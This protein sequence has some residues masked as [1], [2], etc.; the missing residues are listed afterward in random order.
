MEKLYEIRD[1]LCEELEKTAKNGELSTGELDIVHKI[2][3]TIKN[4]DKIC[5]MEE[6]GGYS[7]ESSY[8][9][10]MNGN[11]FARG[12]NGRYSRGGMW[13]ARGDYA[14]GNSYG[15]GRG[16]YSTDGEIDNLVHQMG[17]MMPN[18][19]GTQREAVEKAMRMLR[20]A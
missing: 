6:D 16:R 4:I 9:D 3:D 5:A 15:R 12:R 14:R 7:M 18:L 11:S 17:E 10:G 8:R 13:E 19:D 1:I 2:T 20:E